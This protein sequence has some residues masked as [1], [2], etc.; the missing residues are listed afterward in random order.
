[1]VNWKNY[2][3]AEVKVHLVFIVHISHNFHPRTDPVLWRI[4]IVQTHIYQAI[5]NNGTM[6]R[7]RSSTKFEGLRVMS[8]E[9]RDLYLDWRQRGENARNDEFLKQPFDAVEN[10]FHKYL[11]EYNTRADRVKWSCN[12][13]PN[14]IYLTKSLLVRSLIFCRILVAY[15][16]KHERKVE[17]P[18]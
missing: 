18:E 9:E 6:K 3:K 4:L 5:K 15:P 14:D 7:N 8:L 13:L 1:M 16:S 2:F 12:I 11:S 10:Y 17:D